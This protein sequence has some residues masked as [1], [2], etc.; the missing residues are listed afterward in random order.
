MRKYNILL[1]FVGMTFVILFVPLAI[2]G[3]YI[4][5]LISLCVGCGVIDYNRGGFDKE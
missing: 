3:H 4:Y 2:E 5:G 1:G